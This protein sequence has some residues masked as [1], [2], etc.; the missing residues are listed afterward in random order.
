[1]R[2]TY[3]T[4]LDLKKRHPLGLTS[5]TDNEYS[6]F[7]NHIIRTIE[8]AGIQDI[9]P[10]FI[11]ETAL[12]LT[13][14]FEDRVA[15]AG[16]FKAFTGK[17]K[18]MYGKVLPFYEVDE[19]EYYDDEPNYEDVRLIIWYSRI[20]Y[21][22][23]QL[24]NPENPAIRMLAEDVFELMEENFE[25]ISINEVLKDFLTDC[26]FLDNFYMLR[27]VL[28]WISIGCY[29]TANPYATDD[30]SDAAEMT[31]R[32]IMPYEKALYLHECLY[33]FHTNSGIMA[34]PAAE[35]LSLILQANGKQEEA[36]CVKSIEAK[37]YGYYLLEE[38]RKD[39]IVFRA[40]DDSTFFA[41][42][43][44]INLQEDSEI[45][46]IAINAFVKYK[47]E[48]YLNGTMHGF[49]EVE[50]FESMKEEE[51]ELANTGVP[52]YDKLMA[53]SGGSPLFYFKN[54][55]ALIKFLKEVV[56]VKN[57]DDY[58]GD[59]PS[60]MKD[61][62]WTL[63][64]PSEDKPFTLLPHIAACIKDKRNPYY[65]QETAD[66]GALQVLMKVSHELR[67]YLTSHNML[68]DARI[69]SLNGKE[70]GRTLVQENMDFLARAFLREEY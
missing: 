38:M 29:L 23:G 67:Q 28:K 62:T 25:T 36:L 32:E 4:A 20:C 31:D 19:N 58:A 21:E 3:V 24:A 30:I 65:N 63:F 17:M 7:A 53:L 69:M 22:E 13:L 16:I 47:G 27:E 11:K 43:N 12:N 57:I 54:H 9:S 70:R 10:E 60:E 48:W 6:S 14:Y 18:E 59:I 8:A 39:G 66:E 52:D 42:Y 44:N 49:A 68:P 34:L 26:T 41:P 33:P 45:P 64:I 56:E 61:C 51:K 55:E 35:W 2:Q 46:R 37:P 50:P 5:F 15:D 40:A 1:M